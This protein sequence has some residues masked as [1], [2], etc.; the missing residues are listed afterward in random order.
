MR[1]DDL[2][3]T[4]AERPDAGD[5]NAGLLARR[6]AHRPH[7]ALAAIELL[8]SVQTSLLDSWPR[9]A[10]ADRARRRRDRCGSSDPHIRQFVEPMPHAQVRTNRS[11][12][13]PRMLFVSAAGCRI[14]ATPK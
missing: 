1:G 13:R 7:G 6:A 3:A 9:L 8:L 5:A 4:Y 14:L 11:S 12:P 10:I 2:I